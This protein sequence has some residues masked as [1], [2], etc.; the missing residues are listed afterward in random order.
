MAGKYIITAIAL[1]VTY[2]YAQ[3]ACNRS[4]YGVPSPDSTIFPTTSSLS[5]LEEV[6][7]EKY[8]KV[9]LEECNIKLDFF[10]TKSPDL[11]RKEVSWSAEKLFHDVGIMLWPFGPTNCSLHSRCWF[12]VLFCGRVKENELKYAYEKSVSEAKPLTD[13][14]VL[15]PMID[16]FNLPNYTGWTLRSIHI[17][18]IINGSEVVVPRT[19]IVSAMPDGSKAGR[20]VVVGEYVLTIPGTYHVDSRV[21]AFYPGTLYD[22]DKAQRTKGLDL[23]HMIAYG[24]VKKHIIQPSNIWNTLAP[25]TRLR[26]KASAGEVCEGDTSHQH[27]QPTQALPFCTNGN[28]PGRWITIPP[29]M[30]EICRATGYMRKIAP[31]SVS[32]HDLE[33]QSRFQR[34][35]LQE[36]STDIVLTT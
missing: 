23:L 29:F 16:K 14:K 15:R 35:Y 24:T 20:E 8:F 13:A 30:L 11:F 18:T 34:Q 4:S 5:N 21:Q 1:F 9:G 26:V 7:L 27:Q 6:E 28:H 32:V 10:R 33:A 36:V 31:L 22:F 2:S 12:G 17:H 19:R 3:I 25:D